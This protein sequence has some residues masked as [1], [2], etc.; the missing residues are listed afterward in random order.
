MLK[1]KSCF[2]ILGRLKPPRCLPKQCEK[3][4]GISHSTFELAD[5][6]LGYVFGNNVKLVKILQHKYN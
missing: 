3:P 4:P 1:K 5:I 2:I 6:S